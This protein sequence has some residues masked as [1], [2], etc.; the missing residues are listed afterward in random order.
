MENLKELIISGLQERYPEA[1][2][3]THRVVKNNGSVH[4]GIMMKL[5]PDNPCAPVIYY[6]QYENWLD[7]GNHTLD[8]VLDDIERQ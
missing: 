4:D 8:D 6:E 1:T 7:S 2:F 3:D 5:T